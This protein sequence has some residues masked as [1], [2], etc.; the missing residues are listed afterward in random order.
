M[1]LTHDPVASRSQDSVAQ[2]K[3]SQYDPNRFR[4]AE[5][6]IAAAAARH[7]K[8]RDRIAVSGALRHVDPRLGTVAHLPCCPAPTYSKE[9]IIIRRRASQLF[10]VILS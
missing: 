2:S 10:N 5:R 8:R 4:S 3:A 9:V 7:E 6:C 1:G